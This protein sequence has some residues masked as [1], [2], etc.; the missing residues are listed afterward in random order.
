MH[1]AAQKQ[2]F[3]LLPLKYPWHPF[4]ILQVHVK[5]FHL[6]QEQLSHMQLN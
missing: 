2:L 4:Q 6:L 1:I 3:L 5:H